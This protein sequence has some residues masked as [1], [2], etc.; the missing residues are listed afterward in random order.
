LI[1][2]ELDEDALSIVKRVWNPTLPDN[3]IF[4]EDFGVKITRHDLQTLKGLNWLNDEVINFYLN[5]ISRRS[6]QHSYLPKVCGLF[7]SLYLIFRLMPL[8]PFFFKN[9]NLA[10]SLLSSDGLERS[11]YLVMMWC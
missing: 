9:S 7:D 2:L 8:T 11:T 3:E 4:S 10:D 5:M 1:F 6:E